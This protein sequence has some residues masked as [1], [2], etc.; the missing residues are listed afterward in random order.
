[1][2]KIIL[3]SSSLHPALDGYADEVKPGGMNRREFISRASAL[4]ATAVAAYGALGL[5]VP[6]AFAG[7]TKSGGVRKSVV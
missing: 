6:Q 5:T 2:T 1:M 3:K 7:E 4:G